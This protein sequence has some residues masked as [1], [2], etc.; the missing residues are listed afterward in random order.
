MRVNRKDM[1]DPKVSTHFI[2]TKKPEV[3]NGELAGYALIAARF[4][5][6]KY[7][8]TSVFEIGSKMDI[9][10]RDDR[11]PDSVKYCYHSTIDS[12]DSLPEGD[13]R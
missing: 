9:W 12:I 10:V 5:K 6:T 7:V 1:Y 13:E 4:A 3:Y 2:D 11:R 8:T